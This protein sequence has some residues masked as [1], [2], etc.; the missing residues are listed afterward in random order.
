ME[1]LLLD[2]D[3]TL[4]RP[5]GYRQALIGTVARTAEILGFGEVL[6]DEETI[7]TFE[8]A[9]VTNGWDSAAICT[10]LLLDR[11]WQ[12]DSGARLPGEATGWHHPD[13]QLPAPDF[14]AFAEALLESAASGQSPADRSKAL[15]SA[16]GTLRNP[17]QQAQL[18]SILN[19][20]HDID[21]SLTM[22]IYQELVLGSQLFES[23]YGYASQ[24]GLGSTLR[25][26]DRPNLSLRAYQ[27]LQDWVTQDG[28]QAVLFTNRP[29][30][31][32][33]GQGGTPEAEI[34]ATSLSLENLP[35]LGMGG[36]AW[37]STQAGLADNAYLK[38]SPLHALAALQLALGAPLKPALK[39][40]EDLLAGQPDESWAA[41]DGARVWVLEDTTGGLRSVQ[42]AAGHLE[43]L[44]VKIQVTLFGI[45]EGRVKR[46]ALAD[47]GAAVYS[48]L[49]LVLYSVLAQDEE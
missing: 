47:Q 18:A 20:S 38:P 15:L 45:A 49:N 21:R 4:L 37:L 43:A 42:S 25:Q 30:K 9:G 5:G 12:Q 29:S 33:D 36:P 3:G 32:P 35:L 48:D 22:K 39:V 40:S 10:A 24:L 34:G 31:Y 23:E 6:L 13:H 8:V 46:R 28:H 16:N 41:L 17:D 14:L 44:G 19:D 1:I 2:I 26:F 27:M 11:L 7:A